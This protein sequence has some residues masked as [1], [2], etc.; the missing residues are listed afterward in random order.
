MNTKFASIIALLLPNLLLAQGHH[1][2]AQPAPHLATPLPLF[3]PTLHR[4]VHNQRVC[5]LV[6]P[7]FTVSMPQRVL[8]NVELSV[9]EGAKTGRTLLF[10]VPAGKLLVIEQLTARVDLPVG[11]SV[12]SFALTSRAA[13]GSDGSLPISR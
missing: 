2:S 12:N 4:P 7:V 6:L 10:N 11:Q 13:S 3:H 1:V 9:N 8:S 5:P